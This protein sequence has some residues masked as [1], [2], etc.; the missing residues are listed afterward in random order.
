MKFTKRPARLRK[1][2]KL[3]NDVYRRDTWKMIA[4]L[5]KAVAKG[6]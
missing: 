6:S 3:V 4:E 2:S 5:R 1:H